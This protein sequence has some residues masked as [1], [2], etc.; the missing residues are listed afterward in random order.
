M[1]DF[2]GGPEIPVAPTEFPASP[3]SLQGVVSSGKSVKVALRLRKGR[4]K[5]VEPGHKS[6]ECPDRRGAATPAR[7]PGSSSK[8]TP[9]QTK[10][11]QTEVRGR[12]NHISEEE[13]KVAPDVHPEVGKVDI[14]PLR[15]SD[16]SQLCSI[17]EKTVA[18]VP[19]VCEYP[20][21]FPDDLPGLP[22][23]RDIEFEINLEPGTAPIAQRPYRMSVDE[24]EELKKQLHELK[25]K[26]YIRPSASPWASPVLFVKKKDGSMRMCIDYRA[27]NAVTI[28][29][30][31]PLPRIDELLDQLK[32]AKFFSK[33]DLRS[34]FYQMKIRPCDIPKTAFVTR[35]GQFE[36]T[37]VSFGLTNAPPY[38]MNMMNKVFMDELD[39]FVVVFIDDILIYSETAED[40]EKHLGIV[41]EKLRQNQ[42]YAKF[43]KCEFW[44]EKVAFLG[45]VLSAEGVAV[46]PEKV[47]AVSEWQQ[48]KNVTEIRS[49]LGLAG[50]YRR[51]IEN[52]SRIAKP[53]TELLKEELRVAVKQRKDADE[54]L[55]QV[56]EQQKQLAKNLED[57]REENN[58][59]SRELVQAQKHLADKKVLDE[60]LEQAARRMSELEESLR[61]MKKSNDDL[62]EALNRIA[63]LEKAA[64]PV[65]KALVP[66]DPSA[67]LSF[68]ERLKAMPRQLKAYIKRSSKA[69]LVHV[70][71][72]VK[73]RYPEVD[74]DKLVEGAEPNCTESAFRDLKQEAE[75]VAEAIVQSLRL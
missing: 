53:M 32:R 60:K 42:L 74:I 30:K 45:H 66:E 6:Y 26:G 35:Y 3:A 10:T 67:P 51:F 68:L 70:L 21:V 39:C 11:Q 9:A 1:L 50:Y 41:L 8:G 13:A 63:L 16:V 34:G 52:F 38:F 65:V 54:Q 36:F 73:S 40:H 7:A 56:L 75:P 20:D 37:V 27:L 43:S 71:A 55:F 33:I 12:L 47:T 31:Y 14:V 58:R 29:N 59:L 5:L 23:D 64:N 25:E 48:P 15:S 49:F 28:K 18:D 57:A 17:T 61:L 2:P 19:V 62:A 24:L 4:S 69:C 46:D 44:L 72:V 22:P